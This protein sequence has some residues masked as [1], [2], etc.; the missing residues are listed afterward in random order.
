MQYDSRLTVLFND[1]PSTVKSFATI[2]YEG[3]QARITSRRNDG[4][5]FNLNSKKGW[6]VDN[7][8]TNLQDTG[9]LEFKNKEGK[10]FSYIKGTS[11]S[12]SNLD[13]TEF[14]VQGIGMAMQVSDEVPDK[15][16][17]NELCLTIEPLATCGS[18]YGCMD[19]NS[20]NYNPNATVDDGT[21]SVPGCTD[22]LYMNYNP[23]ATSD[24]GS[25]EDLITPG[26]MDITA[27]NYNPNAN[28]DDGSCTYSCFCPNS[29]CGLLKD[30]CC[31]NGSIIADLWGGTND[32]GLQ[33]TTVTSSAGA[34]DAGFGFSQPNAVAPIT[35]L[36]P[37]TTFNNWDNP[38]ITWSGNTVSLWW[39]GLGQGTY[40]I[41]IIDANGCEWWESLTIIDP[42]GAF[43]CASTGTVYDCG[44]SG[45]SW[46]NDFPQA[47][48]AVVYYKPSEMLISH[49]TFGMQSENVETSNSWVIRD[50][51]ANGD[52]IYESLAQFVIA[53]ATGEEYTDDMIQAW[54][55]LTAAEWGVA[56]GQEPIITTTSSTTP[57][58]QVITGITYGGGAVGHMPILSNSSIYP[59]SWNTAVDA[60]NSFVTDL[61]TTIFNP[62]LNA[63]NQSIEDVYVIM[64]S[65]GTGD[66]N[67]RFLETTTRCCSPISAGVYPT[68]PTDPCGTIY[69]CNTCL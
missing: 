57:G 68:S 63:Q 43:P 4:E 20:S 50:V 55:N 3:T 21:C 35:I 18:V 24:D 5:Y 10:W 51:D 1:N 7:I 8:I 13:E 56:A 49:P 19:P 22:P 32:L 23:N 62:P 27:T 47:G 42:V 17:D 16:V 66:R 37:T 25:C 53:V 58:F 48:G 30:K 31:F 26:C 41:G 9:E 6:Y 14:S 46:Y 59:K 34:T 29:D 64:D 15:P 69:S 12:L 11:T 33:T 61:G 28:T 39:D 40:E 52:N 44:F 45:C 36:A 67:D 2:N 60:L 65:I 54:H 38:L